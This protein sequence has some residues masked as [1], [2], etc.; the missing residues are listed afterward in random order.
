MASL[1]DDLNSVVTSAVN[2]RVEAQVA[3]AL[4][5]GEYMKQFVNAALHTMVK[6]NNYGEKDKPLVSFVL[7]KAI[8]EQAKQVVNE[9]I[10]ALKPAIR[11]EVRVALEKSVGVIADSLVDG[12]VA[13]ASGRYPSIEVNFRANN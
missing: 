11:E 9:E 1:N 2:A 3:E 13:N 12:F 6:S 7:E 10:E 5:G 4:S 8:Q